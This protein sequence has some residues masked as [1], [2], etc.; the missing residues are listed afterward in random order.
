MKNSI[1]NEARI[2]FQLKNPVRIS[3]V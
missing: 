1:E 3:Y 2:V